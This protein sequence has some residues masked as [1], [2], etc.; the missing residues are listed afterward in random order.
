MTTLHIML[1]SG[2]NLPNLIPAIANLPNDLTF[3][4]NA[5]L[6]LTSKF[7]RE[8]ARTLKMALE[9]TG[10]NTVSVHPDDCPDHDLAQLRQWAKAR[11]EEIAGNYHDN[12]RIVNLT[13]GNKLMTLAFFEAFQG[14][15]TEL[16]YCDTEHDRIEY[17]RDDQADP[18]LPV[19]ILKLKPYLAAQGFRLREND[20]DVQGIRQRTD[21]TRKLAEAAPRISGLIQA[22]NGAFFEYDKPGALVGIVETDRLNP[23]EKNLLAD[24]Q[25]LNLLEGRQLKKAS[26]ARYLG[27]GW[28]EE[29][30]WVIGQE[31]EQ[32][33]PGRR[34]SRDRWGI[35]QKID[36]FENTRAT[37][38]PL[39][40][41]DTVFIHRNRMLLIECKTGVQLS[42]TGKGQDILNKLE[43]LG[44]HV[45]G[46]LNTKWLLTARSLSPN[47]QVKQRAEHY[48]IRIVK[49]EELKNLKTMV[50]E[51]MTR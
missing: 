12:R 49:P 18:R 23:E 37:L 24:I 36:A 27:G 31:L 4:A 13:G 42:E 28:L 1:A 2:E 46:R 17:L 39:N 26:A 22:L 40:E 41:L 50:Q 21:L 3:K 15:T 25:Q 48:G 20:T 19:N 29:W 5:A 43:A 47:A 32:A 30:C 34:L 33:D 14:K 8:K 10:V 51:W 45:S 9:F 38:Y 6:I 44:Q 7:M 16:I 35:S 11:A